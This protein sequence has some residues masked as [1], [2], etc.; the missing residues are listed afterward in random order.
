MLSSGERMK[1]KFSAKGVN[2]ILLQHQYYS[3]INVK[4]V[5]KM[6]EVLQDNVAV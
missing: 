6:F 4:P 1:V 5:G 2:V 3:P